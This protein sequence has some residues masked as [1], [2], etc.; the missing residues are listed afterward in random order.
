MHN[1]YLSGIYLW[2]I[3]LN[4]CFFLIFINEQSWLRSC[5][6]RVG[7]RVDTNDKEVQFP[8]SPNCCA[9]AHREASEAPANPTRGNLLFKTLA[10]LDTPSTTNGLSPRELRLL[11]SSPFNHIQGDK[12]RS[13]GSLLLWRGLGSINGFVANGELTTN[14]LGELSMT[15]TWQGA[16]Q[17]NVKTTNIC[18]IDRKGKF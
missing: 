7:K 17:I 18:L 14:D 11:P 16:Y 6:N 13:H 10:S 2:R 4:F 12:L 9:D 15:G 3:K 8:E 5:E 1:L